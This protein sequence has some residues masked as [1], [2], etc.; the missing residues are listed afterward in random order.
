MFA[1]IPGTGIGSILYFVLTLHMLLKECYR[2]CVKR[3]TRQSRRL[4]MRQ[5]VITS[6]IIGIYAVLGYLTFI[7]VQW[8]RGIALEQPSQF[9]SELIAMLSSKNKYIYVP[10]YVFLVI[11]VGTHSYGLILRHF[12]RHSVKHFEKEQD[13]ISLV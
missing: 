3:S 12:T 6:T 2:I 7:I 8:L 11:T 10:V 4:V 1:G 13:A 5:V 9:L